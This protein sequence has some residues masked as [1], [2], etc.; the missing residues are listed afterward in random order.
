MAAMLRAVRA[1]AVTGAYAP[2]EPAGLLA[3]LQVRWAKRGKRAK[4]PKRA[5]RSAEQVA[6]SGGPQ[7]RIFDRVMEPET[8]YQMSLTIKQH[9]RGLMSDGRH[10]ARRKKDL[11]R[12][13]NYRVLRIAGMTHDNPQEEVD[14]RGFVTPLTELQDSSHLPRSSNHR[15][16]SYPH[17]LS[18]KVYWGP[19]SVQDEPNEYEGSMVG[20][21]VAVRLC[22]LPLTQRQKERLIDIV[23]QERICEKSGVLALEADTFP[24]RNQNAA[25]LGDMMEQLL[26]EATMADELTDG[27][28][29]VKR[30][31]E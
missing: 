23:G 28:E 7:E 11:S 1:V 15:R 29:E 16:F 18:Y 30:P 2:L 3:P 27:R 12:Y 4:R 21:T 6:A 22:D 19:P 17:T 13:T 14:R 24:E 26:R 25:L 9:M 31:V 20:C 10:N 8:P 5:D